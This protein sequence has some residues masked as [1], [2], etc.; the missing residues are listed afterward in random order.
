MNPQ[1]LPF[2]CAYVKV[3]VVATQYLLEVLLRTPK[4][5]AALKGDGR[6]LAVGSCQYRERGKVVESSVNFDILKPPW[7]KNN[8]ASVI[9]IKAVLLM[10]SLFDKFK[11][12]NF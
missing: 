5:L 9:L 10:L 11:R 4:A 7:K 2:G 8:K 6:A 3:C 1:K 12:D